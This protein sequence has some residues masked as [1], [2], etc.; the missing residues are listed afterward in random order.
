MASSGN[1]REL[2]NLWVEETESEIDDLRDIR[3]GLRRRVSELDLE[4]ESIWEEQERR[5]RRLEGKL[6]KLSARPGTRVN[7][8]L[9]VNIENLI[10][11]IDE[12]YADLDGLLD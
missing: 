7:P 10:A 6:K 11:S 4:G 5:W 9:A 8:G 1:R 12:A 2:G 3:A